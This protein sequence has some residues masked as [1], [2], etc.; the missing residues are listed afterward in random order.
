MARQDF[1]RLSVLQSSN[2]C[3]KQHL[4]VP[5]PWK[6]AVWVY[7]LRKDDGSTAHP[8]NASQNVDGVNEHFDGLFEFVVCGETFIENDQFA[9][10]DISTSSSDYADLLDYI[11]GLNE[12]LTEKCVR[13]FICGTALH[14]GAS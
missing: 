9:D 10:M 3:H 4:K 5:S 1:L 7:H 11:D 13:I 8:A 12:P 2:N 14:I 6:V